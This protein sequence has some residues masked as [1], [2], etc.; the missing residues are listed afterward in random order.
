MSATDKAREKLV[1]S[2]RKSKT[3][4]EKTPAPAKKR[5]SGKRPSSSAKSRP[6][7]AGRTAKT[8]SRRATGNSGQGGA[9]PYQAM[10]RVWPD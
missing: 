10:P 9:D 5:A 3:G 2:M 1:D 6:G 8:A 4:S 7:A